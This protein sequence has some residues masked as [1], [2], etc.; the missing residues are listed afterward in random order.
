ML[1]DGRL[2]GLWKGRKKGDVLEVSFEWLGEEADVGEEADA[3]A[4]L[5][6]CT[7]RLVSP[8]TSPG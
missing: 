7:A 8:S 6:G 2:A 3:I 5:R 1:V 4:R